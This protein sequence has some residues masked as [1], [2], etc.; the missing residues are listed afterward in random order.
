M[1]THNT[2]RKH[3]SDSENEDGTFQPG[4][5]D[6]PGAAH[7][8]KRV[9]KPS[10]RPAASSVAATTPATTR[11]TRF[12][13]LKASDLDTEQSDPTVSKDV[14][15]GVFAN[16]LRRGPK[17]RRGWLHRVEEA[18]IACHGMVA[19]PPTGKK[20][21]TI[22]PRTKL[23][24]EPNNARYNFGGVRVAL[25]DPD[26]GPPTP[27]NS[28][29]GYLFDDAVTGTEVVVAG[30]QG[31][32]AQDSIGAFWK[33]ASLVENFLN[34]WHDRFGGA[35]IISPARRGQQ[36]R[37][38][39]WI[40][41]VFGQG[42]VQAMRSGSTI[43]VPAPMWAK[44]Q[45]GQ[46]WRAD[47]N[48]IDKSTGASMTFNPQTKS[49]CDFRDNYPG[50]PANAVV[51]GG[52]RTTTPL[53]RGSDGRYMS[54]LKMSDVP[55][56]GRLP[57][58]D[59]GRGQAEM[60]R[61]L[62]NRFEWYC[63]L[64]WRLCGVISTRT[65]LDTIVQ[66]LELE[67]LTAEGVRHQ[68]P[69]GQVSSA[70][71][72]TTRTSLFGLESLYKQFYTIFVPRVDIFRALGVKL[73]EKTTFPRPAY[74]SIDLSLAMQILPGAEQ[75]AVVSDNPLAAYRHIALGCDLLN[76]QLKLGLAPNR[77]IDNCAACNKLV[78]AQ[79]LQR[80][81]L[82]RPVCPPCHSSAVS[83]TP[84]VL[85]RLKKSVELSQKRDFKRTGK[86][87]KSTEEEDLYADAVEFLDQADITNSTFPDGYANMNIV[88]VPP[89]GHPAMPS[90]DACHRGL[91]R[92]NHTRENLVVTKTVKNQAKYIHL[93]GQ[94]QLIAD[95]YVET[96]SGDL[97]KEA[98]LERMAQLLDDVQE[99]TAIRL[100]H[101]YLNRTGAAKYTMQEIQSR[102][103]ELRSGKLSDTDAAQ[104][105]DHAATFSDTLYSDVTP[106]DS[107]SSAAYYVVS[108]ADWTG[109]RKT[110]KAIA[111]KFGCDYVESADGAPWPTPLETMPP[112]WNRQEF[113]SLF[114]ARIYRLRYECNRW[115]ETTN[116]VASLACATSYHLHQY[117]A[118]LFSD[119]KAAHNYGEFVGLPMTLYRNNPLM[120]SIGKKVPGAEMRSGFAETPSSLDDY[121]EAQDTLRVDTTFSNFF[122]YDYPEELE[123]T[124]Q[125]YVAEIKVPSEMFDKTIHVPT[126]ATTFPTDTT[127]LIEWESNVGSD[128]QA[129]P[130]DLELL[131]VADEDAPIVPPPP[132]TATELIN[133][134]QSRIEDLQ[135][136]EDSNIRDMFS[137]VMNSVGVPTEFEEA[138][139]TIE[140]ALDAIDPGK[141]QG[142]GSGDEEGVGS[143]APQDEISALKDEL[144]NLEEQFGEQISGDPELDSLYKQLE[145]AQR[146]GD[147]PTYESLRRT[148]L[149]NVD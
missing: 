74:S 41:L 107:T 22:K 96:R 80:D 133:N 1:S 132:P 62:H 142:I 57:Q 60:L 16:G 34:N 128:Y 75:A 109:I 73:A 89:P 72:T 108:E 122:R 115:W 63:Y 77:P 148:F 124:L 42:V 48:F 119:H 59:V 95:F 33:E 83:T 138:V 144:S 118:K 61:R 101:D 65:R 147:R 97:S 85:Q 17:K 19:H 2:K 135:V 149:Q 91:Y 104:W 7:D 110:C 70:T 24:R 51:S 98:L 5:G 10:G 114:I 102:R 69:A 23:P 58:S 146:H 14:G 6:S 20:R 66:E 99:M 120:L 28:Q 49:G 40:R 86:E 76:A 140:S 145:K 13:G 100:K 43:N 36:K 44:G 81:Y 53:Q 103:E 78:G 12:R 54:G 112:S 46:I 15:T 32:G 136:G 55:Q 116:T 131:N 3:K 79:H 9:M 125:G 88:D 105:R 27:G 67:Y 84:M 71:Q 30:V 18:I 143:G 87:P 25:G 4:A 82:N 29:L 113:K 47:I 139:Q 134:I 38:P 39:E 37:N 64:Q 90:V 50:R 45:G 117:Y 137:A 31:S 56:Q 111:I 106:P 52:F 94:M 35:R 130:L 21:Y 121:H 123:P 126:G 127:A 68:K 8:T 141:Q 93:V 11:S 92:R 26:Q 129:Y